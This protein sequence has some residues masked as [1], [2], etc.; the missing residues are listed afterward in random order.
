MLV[1]GLLGLIGVGTYV[2]WPKSPEA[3]S[4]VS[5]NENPLIASEG[6]D[7]SNSY[8]KNIQALASVYSSSEYIFINDTTLD[9]ARKN[10]PHIGQYELDDV[11]LA[12]RDNSSYQFFVRNS[13]GTRLFYVIVTRTPDNLISL[14]FYKI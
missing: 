9:Y 11:S 6:A 8:L 13:E 7:I 14:G 5:A 12:K 3:P 4:D 10:F 2:L 1:V